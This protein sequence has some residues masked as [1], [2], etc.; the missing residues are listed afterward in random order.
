M[1]CV[2]VSQRHQ[3][4]D[5]FCHVLLAKSEEGKVTD[6]FRTNGVRKDRDG[7]F[8]PRLSVFAVIVLV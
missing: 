4:R 8:E 6:G 5:L 2:C 7:G 1:H 3:L